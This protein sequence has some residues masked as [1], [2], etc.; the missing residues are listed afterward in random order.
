VPATCWRKPSGIEESRLETRPE[1]LSLKTLRQGIHLD[2]P[3]G[4]TS[5]LPATARGE[6]WLLDRADGCQRTSPAA[7]SGNEGRLEI[8]A[9]DLM[10]PRVLAACGVVVRSGTRLV[11]G[12]IS[13][14]DSGKSSWTHRL[15]TP[16]ACLPRLAAKNGPWIGLPAVKEHRQ[17][18]YPATKGSAG[19]KLPAGNGALRSP[20]FNLSAAVLHRCQRPARTNSW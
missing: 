3:F 18:R 19:G 15:E 2:S 1:G 7:L 13:A 16:P 12:Y 6:E 4:D 10:V 20:A 9:S 11:L 14:S 17:R 8:G 5:G